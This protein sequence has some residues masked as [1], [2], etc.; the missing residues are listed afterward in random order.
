MR[1]FLGVP[2]RLNDE[3]IG[4]IGVANRAGPYQDGHERLLLTYAAQIAIVI[5][6]A[7]LYERLANTN[8]E[9]ERKVVERT[10]QLH[11][12]SR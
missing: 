8:A 2:L 6:N 7:Q 3:P 1:T 10:S 5:R 4:M 9:L 11:E 12:A